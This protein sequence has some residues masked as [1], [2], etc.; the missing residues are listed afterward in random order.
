MDALMAAL[1]AALLIRATDKTVPWVARV[2]ERSGRTGAVLA[3]TFL[4]LLVTQSI[5]AVA[6]ALL[7]PHLN[8]HAQRLLFAFALLSAGLGAIWRGKPLASESPQRPLVAVTA[9]LISIGLG[10]RTQFATI[11]VAAGGTAGL[12]AA[13]GLIGSVVVLGAAALAGEQ[14]W[15]TL[16]DRPVR[17]AIG[18]VL[19]AVGAWLAVSALRLI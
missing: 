14:L 13:G 11:A 2:A 9:R 4:A 17:Y 3:A 5:A 7:A 15:R 1:V 8:T 16:P 6:G 12:A 10:D 19:L 18:G